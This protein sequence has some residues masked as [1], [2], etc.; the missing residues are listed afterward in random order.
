MP[1]AFKRACAMGL[2]GMVS[3]RSDSR[4]ISDRTKSWLKT[5]N[6]SARR[7]AVSR[8]GMRNPRFA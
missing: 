4:Y 5:K 8:S 7:H 1:V 6:R 3:K 2:E